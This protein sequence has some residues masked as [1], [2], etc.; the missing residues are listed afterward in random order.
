MGQAALASGER[1]KRD[2]T[3]APRAAQ[4]V[5]GEATMTTQANETLRGEALGTLRGFLQGWDRFWFQPDQPTTLGLI[6]ICTGVIVL[7]VHLVYSFDLQGMLGKDA[8]INQERMEKIRRWAPV[9]VGGADWSGQ[10]VQSAPDPQTPEEK[11]AAR[12]YAEEWGVTPQLTF[13]R[14]SRIWSV[15]FHLTDPTWMVVVHVLFLVSMFLFIIG[16]GTRLTAVLTWIG[17]I[18]YVQRIPTALFGMDTMMMILLVYLMIGPSGAALSVDRLLARWWA[19]RR[20]ARAGKP[21]PEAQPPR[22]YVTANFTLRL[23]QIHV[24]IIY[25]AA[26]LSK[27][28]GAAWWNGTAIWGTIANPEFAPMHLARYLDLLQFICQ[29]RLLWELVTSGGV[30][31]TLFIEIGFPFLVWVKQLRWLMLAT[32]VMLHVGIAL[33]M[34]LTT[35]SLMMMILLL[36]FV[37]AVTVQRW[38]QLAGQSVRALPAGPRLLSPKLELV[39]SHAR[40]T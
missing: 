14:G 8:W 24:C 36:S 33:A 34:G 31:F 12:R 13:D 19:R 16:L 10:P 35:F 1:V 37:P 27:L 2:S 28:Q 5:S 17:A 29:H 23:M 15:W 9:L 22:T 3:S 11:E 26:G 18:S 25:L 40:K 39:G 4:H 7:Y 30:A 21:A 6:R 32:A 38:L 20:T